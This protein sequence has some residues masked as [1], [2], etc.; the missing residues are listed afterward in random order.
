MVK[1]TLIILLIYLS[2]SINAQNSILDK[3]CLKLTNTV[4]EN[5]LHNY[6]TRVD[7][8][9][10]DHATIL[11]INIIAEDIIEY[12]ISQSKTAFFL[13]GRT[14]A[15]FIKINNK[16][17]P[18]VLN[19]IREEYFPFKLNEEVKMEFMRMYLPNEYK[20]YIEYS[21]YRPPF[22]GS[23]VHWVLTFKDNRLIDKEII[24]DE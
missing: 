1:I 5:E 7:T 16:Y 21:N 3:H 15:F 19:I 11:F 13:E 10:D 23:S 4:L 20:Y 12:S 2:L 6:C 9:T 17:L 22:D 8:A 18:V 24:I 14:I